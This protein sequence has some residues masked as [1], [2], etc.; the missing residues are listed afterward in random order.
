M[1]YPK[2]TLRNKSIVQL[3]KEG[4]TYEKIGR[5][6]GL[7]RSRIHKICEEAEKWRS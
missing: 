7:V 5:E 4:W 3:R 1:S 6:F 2:K